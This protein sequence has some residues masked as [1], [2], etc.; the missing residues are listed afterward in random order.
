MLLHEVLN[1]ILKYK[2]KTNFVI[3]YSYHTVIL[4]FSVEKLVS[5]SKPEE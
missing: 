4:M 3:C 1:A 5:V 2:F